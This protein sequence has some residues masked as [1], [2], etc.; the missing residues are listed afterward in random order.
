MRMLVGCLT[1]DEKPWTSTRSRTDLE[2][3][4][5]DPKRLEGEEH[6]DAS[7]LFC[8]HFAVCGVHM[9]SVKKPR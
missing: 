3:D 4:E 5:M 8:A 6:R 1:D 7:S 9:V 2:M